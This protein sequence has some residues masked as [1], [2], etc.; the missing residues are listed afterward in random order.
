MELATG[1]EAG[2]QGFRGS[3]VQADKSASDARSA[4][5]ADTR[6]KWELTPLERKKR[7]DKKGKP[8]QGG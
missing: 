2:V 5:E 3:G 4:A 8:W 6:A 1:A 7:R